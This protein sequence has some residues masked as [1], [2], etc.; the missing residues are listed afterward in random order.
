MWLVIAPL[1]D[2]LEFAG[3]GM[4]TPHSQFRQLSLGSLVA[5]SCTS[6]PLLCPMSMSVSVQYS[7][8]LVD[9]RRSLQSTEGFMRVGERVLTYHALSERF[10]LPTYTKPAFPS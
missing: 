10:A 1:F 4:M 6:R 9:H 3:M 5:L 7:S 2:P 8:L